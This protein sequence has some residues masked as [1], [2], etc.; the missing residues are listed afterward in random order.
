MSMFLVS[1]AVLWVLGA[2][3]MFLA[4][5]KQLEANPGQRIAHLY[6][7]NHA[8]PVQV[9]LLRAGGMAMLMLS[10][11]LLIQIWDFAALIPLVIGVVPGGVLT[12]QHNHSL[13]SPV[14]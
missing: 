4:S 5:R 9:R 6:D 7:Q 10:A 14:A 11:L 2:A 1:G 8:D 13:K 3:L 12:W